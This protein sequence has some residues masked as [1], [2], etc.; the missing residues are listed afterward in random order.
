MVD[1]GHG[2]T[3]QNEKNMTLTSCALTVICFTPTAPLRVMVI[4]GFHLTSLPIL[5]SP[6][7]PDSTIH[8]GIFLC[9]ALTTINRKTGIAC[10]AKWNLDICAKYD[11]TLSIRLLVEV[12]D[13]V[14]HELD[15]LVRPHVHRILSVIEPLL[16]DEDCCARV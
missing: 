14:L 7:V 2:A 3:A 1:M 15:C 4:L 13:R 11:T 8:A 10:H 6:P 5:F 12:L 16:I 9:C